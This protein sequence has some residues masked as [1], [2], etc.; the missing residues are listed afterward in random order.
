VIARNQE[1]ARAFILDVSRATNDPRDAILVFHGS[2]WQRS[3]ELYHQTQHAS[4]DDL[5]LARSL[6]EQIRDDFKR[7]LA[8]RAAYEEHGLA[9][10]RG[11][12]FLGPPGNGKTHCLRAL[13]RE[14]G[15]PSLYVQSIKARYETEEANLKRVFQRARQLRPCVLVLED[16]DALINRENRSF[17]LNQLDGFE[18]NVGLIVLATT[19][20][21]ERI[22]PAILDRPS[23]FDRKYHFEL[24]ELAERSAYLALWQRKLDAKLSW[25]DE[26]TARLAAATAGFS[27]AYIQ[28]LVV[29][30]LMRSV[31]GERPFEAILQRECATLS[32]D[33]KTAKA[34]SVPHAAADIEDE[35]EA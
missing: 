19:N 30:A 3:Q 2:C 20:H 13:V 10:R 7:F 16:L 1:L 33:M 29:T 18:K 9:W 5:I 6:K 25:S 14:L 4:F 24:P 15:V 28:E 23:R 31:A 12:L 32:A 17:F 21:P 34:A 11:A 27:F 8:S 35:G 22:D 26:T